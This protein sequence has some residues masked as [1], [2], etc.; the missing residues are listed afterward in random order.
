MNLPFNSG[1]QLQSNLMTVLSVTTVTGK[2]HLRKKEYILIFN[3]ARSYTVAYSLGFKGQMLQKYHITNV[4]T[5]HHCVYV[6]LCRV[7]STCLR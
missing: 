3:V 1:Y 7:V 4:F 5:P 6:V 2:M